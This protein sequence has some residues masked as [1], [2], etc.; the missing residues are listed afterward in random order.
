MKRTLQEHYNLI[1]DNKGS[2]EI[3]LKEAKNIF[4]DIIRNSATFEEASTILKQHSIISENIWGLVS[5]PTKQPDWFEIF[6]DNITEERKNPTKEVTDLETKNFNYKDEKNIDNIFGQ[7][8]L[9]GYYAEMKDPN[10]SEKSVE[11]LKNIVAKNLRKNP[12]YYVE[13][14]QFGVKGVGYT[15]NHPGLG[16]TKE[17]KGKYASSGMELVSNE[18]IKSNT[19]DLGKKEYKTKMP[20]K[21][22]VMSVA[23]KSSKGVKKMDVPGKEKKIKLHESIKNIIK[24]I[25]NK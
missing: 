6:K 16:K 3:F 21:I 2:K 1:K 20:K 4:P 19:K 12:L 17:V 8:F 24:N 22:D 5:K 14:Y 13:N 10:N 18:T 23:P 9:T 25:I 15:E 11:E 7:A